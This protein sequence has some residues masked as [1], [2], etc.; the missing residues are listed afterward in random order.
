MGDHDDQVDA[1]SFAVQ[2]LLREQSEKILAEAKARVPK[3]APGTAFSGLR[4]V[5]SSATPVYCG[6]PRGAGKTAAMYA[7]LGSGPYGEV[8]V[9]AK[10]TGNERVMSLGNGRVVFLDGP[11]EGEVR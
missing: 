2:S 10:P 11:L 4:G 7:V 5:L 3:G 8:G 1:I 9:I 6:H